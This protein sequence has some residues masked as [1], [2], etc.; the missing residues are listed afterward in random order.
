VT[1]LDERAQIRAELDGM[2]AHLYGLT[3]GEFEHILG[4]FPIVKDEVKEAA[5]GAYQNI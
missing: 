1:H 2:V 4:K 3:Y 5:L